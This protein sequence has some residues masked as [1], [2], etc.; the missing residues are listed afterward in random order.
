MAQKGLPTKTQPIKNLESVGKIM[1]IEDWRDR[2]YWAIGLW[3]ALRIGEIRVTKW[4]DLIDYE[5]NEVR[6]I[7]HWKIQKKKKDKWQ[8]V[9]LPPQ[10]REIIW[11]CYLEAGTPPAETYCFLA[12]RGRQGNKPLSRWSINQMVRKYIEG[13]GMKT[14]GNPSSHTLRKTMAVAFLEE[15]RAAGDPMAL[16]KTSQLL[17]HDNPATT[18]RYLGLTEKQLFKDVNRVTYD[19]LP[20]SLWKALKT[21]HPSVRNW[22]PMVD[23]IKSMMDGDRL[24]QALFQFF[25]NMNIPEKLKTRDNIADCVDRLMDE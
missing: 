20:A 7:S 18:M 13:F 11:D 22:R 9:A 5:H 3:T 15:L 10:L 14:D 8:P 16:E 23:S 1:T 21:N 24:R 17:R 2:L 6:E 19:I 12:H 25:E 4:G